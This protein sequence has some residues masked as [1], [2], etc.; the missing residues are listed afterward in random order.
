MLPKEW[1]NQFYLSRQI[2]CPD[3]RSFY[4]YRMNDNEF[5]SLKST[6]KTTAL[7]GLEHIHKTVGWNAA[8]VIYASEWWRRE[9]DGSSWSWDKLFASFNADVKVLST[10]RRNLLVETGLRYWGRKVRVINGSSRYLGTIAIEGGLPLNQITSK[11]NDWLGR[12]FRQVIPKY[13]RLHHTGI[14]AENLIGECDY[15]IPN[16]YQNDQV[17]TILGDMVKTVVEFKQKYALQD[18]K[19]PIGVLD[20][21]APSWRENFPLPIGTDVGQKLLS[22]MV[23]IAVKATDQKP[24]QPFRGVRKLGTDG[25]LQLQFEL[26]GFVPFERLNLAE[27]I[28][29]RLDVELVSSDGTVN[30][31]GVALKT[32]Y[33]ARPSLKMPR[34]A[35]TVK[36]DQAA[37]GYRLRLRHL[38]T[39]IY[40]DAIADCEELDREAP[41]TFSQQNDDWILEGVASI[42]TRA[43]QVRILY[44]S[45]L[46]QDN[47]SVVVLHSS[48]PNH[49]IEVSGIIQ[50]SNHDGT[51]F[52]IKTGQDISADRF[53]LQGKLLDFKSLP[54]QVYL[55]MPTLICVNNENER[56]IEISS[57]KLVARS[58]NTRN[59]WLPASDIHQGIVEIRYQDNQGN[60]RFRKKCA[61]LPQDFS[62]RFKP[63]PKSLDGRICLDNTNDV[64][65]ICGSAIRNTMIP[66]ANGILSNRPSEIYP[67]QMPKS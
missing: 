45:Q 21:K 12:V 7:F 5:E 13:S 63:S 48:S 19:D 56:R 28:P 22:D 10:S 60:V 29:S 6:L 33:Q 24:N 31:L 55:G 14:K 61:I 8:F 20:L 46:H 65:V 3:K 64:T 30:S 27:P 54:T 58:A 59:S 52:I 42:S 25:C 47:E 53:Y 40:E 62:V 38:S 15:I 34:Y 44:P 2:T 4:R 16:T 17:Y 35:G 9:Y 41:W 18:C 11:S 23:L 57:S 67:F 51:N 49:L 50:F 26:A 1:L 43:K 32:T 66:E 39:V 36:T 37:N